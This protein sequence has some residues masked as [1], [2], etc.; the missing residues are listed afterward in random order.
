MFSLTFPVLGWFLVI[1]T[2]AAFVAVVL[3]LPRAAGRTLRSAMARAGLLVGINLMLVLAIAVQ[4]N[5]PVP[6]LLRVG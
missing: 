4:V 1:A 3:L 5:E 6:L 2:L